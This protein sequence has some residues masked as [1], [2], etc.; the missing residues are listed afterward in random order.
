MIRK[1]RGHKVTL[2]ASAL[3]SAFTFAFPGAATAKH[4]HHHTGSDAT[5]TEAVI[6]GKHYSVTKSVV[7]APPRS[8]YRILT[9]YDNAHRVFPQ[10]RECKV[11]K[12][13]GSHK[14]VKHTVAPS[15]P[16]GT[17]T[18]I[19]EL[20]EHAP[21]SIEW[22]RISGAFKDVRGYYKL[23]PLD[24]GQTTLVTYA[25][26]VDGGLF[27]PRPLINRQS[28]ID[29]PAVMASLKREAETNVQ[30]AETP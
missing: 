7:K 11:L 3:L 15:G 17:Y 5:V 23:E 2:V 4:H 14:V 24:N 19:L 18:Y 28:R 26:H 16:V 6:D 29:M 13:H 9:D 8:V 30:I 27:M 20:K 22:H 21:R 12:D 25:S 1:I 10:V